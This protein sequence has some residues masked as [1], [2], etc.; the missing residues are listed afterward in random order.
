MRQIIHAPFM[1][2]LT[3]SAE[4][5]FMASTVLLLLMSMNKT[6]DV[7]VP[8]DTD[9][10]TDNESQMVTEALEPPCFDMDTLAGAALHTFRLCNVFSFL[11]EDMGYW[12]KPRSTTWFS[13][14][15]LNQYDDERWIAMFRMT[16]PAVQNLAELLKPIVKKKDTKN[17]LAI[18]VLV[19]VACILFKLTHGASMFFCSEMFAIGRSTVSV[20]LRDVAQAI[21]VSLRSEIA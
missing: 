4:V 10:D 8:T 16:K 11:D 15:L 20:V 17:R 5:M 14:F 12:V 18:P 3:N 19:C 1:D 13:R 9:E 7:Y 2:F 6:V 21:N